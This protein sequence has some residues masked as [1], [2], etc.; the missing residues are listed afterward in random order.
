[1]RTTDPD[2]TT[3]LRQRTGIGAI[4]IGLPIA[5]L[6]GVCVFGV[7]M[8]NSISEFFFSELRE[9][10][11][12]SAAGAGL[13]LLAYEGHHKRGAEWLTDRR[14][15]VL[16][17]FGVLLMTFIPT[18]CGLACCYGPTTLVDRI[19][20]NDTL[21]STLHLLSAGL[22]LAG[23]GVMSFFNFTRSNQIECDR[24]KARR[25]RVYRL[26]GAVIF[27]AIF[28]I[29][30]VKLGMPARGAQ[31]DAAWHFTFWAETVALWAFGVS[32]LI[33]GEALKWLFPALYDPNEYSDGL[34]RG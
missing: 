10:F 22:F 16:S 6:I 4:G 20:T 34:M 21:Q 8:E 32:W 12:V 18:I 27:A 25:N 29:G 19:L 7:R 2:R 3:M 5:L 26:S 24:F 14:V 11:T 33:K 31:W 1:M 30:V 17:G 13:F 28:V 15:S 23:L 9:V